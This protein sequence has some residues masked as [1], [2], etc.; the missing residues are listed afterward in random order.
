MAELQTATNSSFD[1]E[2]REVLESVMGALS[3]AVSDRDEMAACSYLLRHL[4]GKPVPH[5]AIMGS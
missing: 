1:Q 3:S 2:R 5:S 4:A